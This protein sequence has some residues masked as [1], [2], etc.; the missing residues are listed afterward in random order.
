LKKR[1]AGAERTAI[2]WIKRL[3]SGNGALKKS[4]I[5][6]AEARIQARKS[7]A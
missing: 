1:N 2:T 3:A 7:L 5:P 4:A 6:V